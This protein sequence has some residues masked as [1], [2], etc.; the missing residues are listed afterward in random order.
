MSRPV[1]R[2]EDRVV[3]AIE[4]AA[5]ALLSVCALQTGTEPEAARARAKRAIDDVWRRAEAEAAGVDLHEIARR[6]AEEH[7]A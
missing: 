1:S 4:A 6:I 3:L 2:L 5:D 7:R